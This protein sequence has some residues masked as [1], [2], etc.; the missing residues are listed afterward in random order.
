MGQYG[1]QVLTFVE[2]RKKVAVTGN[3]RHLSMGFQWTCEVLSSDYIAYDGITVQ[4]GPNVSNSCLINKQT[5]CYW[6]SKCYVQ[7]AWPHISPI[8]H[9]TSWHYKLLYRSINTYIQCNNTVWSN[10]MNICSS[11]H[12]QNCAR[13]TELSASL[14]PNFGIL[15]RQTLEIQTRLLF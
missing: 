9:I 8:I 14:R 2:E 12:G 15:Y 1:S 10:S 4:N 5:N 13:L 7:F 3:Q 6:R 11:N